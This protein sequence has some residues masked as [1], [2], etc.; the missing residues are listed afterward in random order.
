MTLSSERTRAAV[1]AALLVLTGAVLGIAADRALFSPA[2]IEAMPLTAEALSE[3]L[4]LSAGEAARLGALLDSLHGEVTEAAADG[5]EAFRAATEAAHRQIEASL[6]PGS[7]PAFHAWMQEHREHMMH[8][9]HPDAR[10][11]GMMRGGGMGP[12]RRAPRG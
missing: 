1:A 8:R 2:P 11:P 4:D 3:R 12:G 9:M 10:R 5:P 7:R 6:P